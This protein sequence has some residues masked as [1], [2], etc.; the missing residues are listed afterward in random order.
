MDKTTYGNLVM[1][2]VPHG[3]ALTPPASRRPALE[4]LPLWPKVVSQASIEADHADALLQDMLYQLDGLRTSM[5]RY[6]MAARAQQ[7]ETVGVGIGLVDAWVNN[8]WDQRVRLQALIR[9]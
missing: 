3:T 6:V 1:G 9:E 7:S 2:I 5:A 8:V 4:P